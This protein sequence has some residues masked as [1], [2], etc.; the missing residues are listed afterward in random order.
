ME[1]IYK[2]LLKATGLGA[3]VILANAYLTP[4][5]VGLWDSGLKVMAIGLGFGNVLVSGATVYLGGML[6]NKIE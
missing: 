6:I 2:D 1:K 4:S 3:L 5:F